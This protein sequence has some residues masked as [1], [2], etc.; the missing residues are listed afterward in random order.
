MVD[1]RRF[2]ALCP[3]ALRSWLGLPAGSALSRNSCSV[4]TVSLTM[5]LDP[6]RP[7]WVAELSGSRDRKKVEGAEDKRSE[8]DVDVPA[9][10]NLR[11]RGPAWSVSACVGRI[12]RHHRDTI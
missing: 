11:G 8:G 12:L 3:S 7:C 1:R 10:D 9:D 6:R 2:R 4:D 5:R